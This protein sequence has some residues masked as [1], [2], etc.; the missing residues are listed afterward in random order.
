MS[1]IWTAKWLQDP[2]FDGLEPIDTFGRFNERTE[3]TQRIFEQHK[4]G[5]SNVHMLLRKRFSLENEPA[6]AHIAIT[7]DDYYKLWVNGH[8]VG[9]GPA[10]GYHWSYPY[11]L[12][13]IAPY[14]RQ[15]E[16]VF[17]VHVY[18]IG[19]IVRQ[20][21]S[22]DHR[23]G[24]ICEAA[25]ETRDGKHSQILSDDT[26]KHRIIGSPT[27]VTLEDHNRRKSPPEYYLPSHSGGII[28]ALTQ[29]QENIDVRTMEEGWREP[30][31]GDDHW[32]CPSALNLAAKDYNMVPQSTPALEMYRV[33]PVSV[34][35]R[36]EGRYLIDFGREIVGYFGLTLPGREGHVVEIRHAEERTPT[37][38]ARY[39]MRASTTY[40]E[41]WTLGDKPSHT[42]EYF[43]YKG[44]RYVEVLNATA[45]VTADNCW[46]DMRHYPYPDNC[47]FSSSDP[48]LNRIW[49]ICVH[50]IKCCGQEVRVDCPTRE[51]GHYLGDLLHYG[52]P[53]LLLTRDNRMYRAALDLYA[54]SARINPGLMSITPGNFMMEI[55][56]FS[57]MFPLQIEFYYRHTGDLAVVEEMLPVALGVIQYFRSF[58]NEAGLLAGVTEM[59]NL[60]D[61]D[62]TMRDDYDFPLAPLHTPGTGPHAVL[63]LLYYGALKAVLR[64]REIAGQPS[65][66][67]PAW[68]DR[69]RTAIL[70]A[71]HDADQGVFVDSIGSRHPSLHSNALALYFGIVPEKTRN[72]VLRLLRRKRLA[73]GPHMAYFL[74]HALFRN[75][76][77][78]LAFDLMTSQDDHSWTHMLRDGAT[79]ALEAWSID[80]K[81]NCTWCHSWAAFPVS[82]V[83][84]Y[85][86]GLQ[87]LRPGWDGVLF[88]P[89]MPAELETAFVGMDI[90][91]GHMTV[92][93]RRDGERVRY[94][95]GT[96]PDVT[97]QPRDGLT[98]LTDRTVGQRR[99]R[100]LV[101]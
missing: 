21:N 61:W 92:N 99:V 85:V 24:M 89:W 11:N 1:H 90:P 9:Q 94:E 3:L 19:L 67:L 60:V 34:E 51:K 35:E 15:G 29:F 30:G 26:W 10:P 20:W 82:L 97:L 36:G 75:G 38:E 45:P 23:M 77:T 88:S 17:A 8:F 66:E 80:H 58:E 44:F 76:Q 33:S 65:G 101:G 28:G 79:A 50:A 70:Q 25:I 64:L 72:E 55:A 74:L 81:V 91:Q 54:G 7:A 100:E 63:N 59:W 37:G 49:D 31:F 53:H 4:P 52:E 62:A 42:L 56:D 87:P 18:Y 27:T 57:L 39:Q 43:D 93:A 69:L 40:Q 78:E 83:I 14:L 46:A 86:M 12:W 98:L 71:F 5:L 41:F 73:C 68:R 2:R 13:D 6:A 48:L 95:V 22:L 16:N 84:E 96:P 32:G 47:H